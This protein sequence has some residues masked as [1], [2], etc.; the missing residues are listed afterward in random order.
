MKLKVMKTMM[1]R[2]ETE[3][4]I[5]TLREHLTKRCRDITSMSRPLIKVVE[6]QTGCN[7]TGRG[8]D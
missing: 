1:S 5:S 4:A 2:Q 3:V 7:L 8:R 6:R